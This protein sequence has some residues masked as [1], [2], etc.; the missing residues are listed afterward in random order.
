MMQPG[1][2]FDDSAVVRRRSD[3]FAADTDGEMVVLDSERGD[4]LHL[5]QTAAGIFALLEG[6][7]TVAALRDRLIEKFDVDA[8][9]CGADLRLFLAQ[10]MDRGLVEFCPVEPS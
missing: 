3:V 7:L 1:E 10:L 5:N 8:A 4:F 2:Q 9:T 6:P